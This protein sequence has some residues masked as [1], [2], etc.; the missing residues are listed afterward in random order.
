MSKIY[1]RNPQDKD[2]YIC[3]GNI[4]LVFLKKVKDAMKGNR[5]RGRKQ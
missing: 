2:D 5:K 4:D 1:I 3:V